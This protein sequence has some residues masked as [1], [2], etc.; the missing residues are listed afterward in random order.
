M[1]PSL[2]ISAI[3][4]WT[5]SWLTERHLTIAPEEI[6]CGDSLVNSIHLANDVL[7]ADRAKCR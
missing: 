1:K 5:L 3:A 2:N 6:Q 7:F 4:R